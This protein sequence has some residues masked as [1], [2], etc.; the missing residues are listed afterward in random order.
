MNFCNFF[1]GMFTREGEDKNLLMAEGNKPRSC[2][3]KPP[4]K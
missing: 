4:N 2:P 1:K 3:D